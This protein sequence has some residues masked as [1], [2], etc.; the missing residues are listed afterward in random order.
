MPPRASAAP[1]A[2]KKYIYTVLP[3]DVDGDGKIDGDLI[4]QSVQKKDGTVV[5]VARKFVPRTLIE[6]RIGKYAADAENEAV[7]KTAA[8]AA[9]PAPAAKR[10]A[11]TATR[12]RVVKP[13]SDKRIQEQLRDPDVE[14]NTVYVANNTTFAQ[15]M[16]TGF[17]SGAGLGLGFGIVE[18]VVSSFFE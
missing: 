1:A 18:G 14:K 9:A 13:M 8:A 2:R 12:R 7:E 10:K 4:V 11:A 15:S 6:K 17:A 3:I 5:E 16:A